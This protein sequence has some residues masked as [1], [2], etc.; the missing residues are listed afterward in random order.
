[1]VGEERVAALSGAV[2][3]GRRRVSAERG[4]VDA[5]EVNVDVGGAGIGAGQDAE[6]V[7]GPPARRVGVGAGAEQAAG[8]RARVRR[9]RDPAA[10]GRVGQEA[11]GRRARAA[12]DGR[13]RHAE[14]AEGGGEGGRAS[15]G[16]AE[17][18]G[19]RR[20]TRHDRVAVPVAAEGHVQRTTNVVRLGT[21]TPRR[22]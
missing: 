14:P 11:D 15:A 7:N 12:A 17:A 10:G 19:R 4:A 1:M 3:G 22:G 5:Q 2:G 16:A 6:G 21:T 20:Q 13:L 18:D 9:Q 8:R